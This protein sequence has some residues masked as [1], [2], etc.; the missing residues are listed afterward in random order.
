MNEFILGFNSEHFD[1][2]SG[3]TLLGNG[4]RGYN[5]VVMRSNS[6]DSMSPFGARGIN[7]YTYCTCDPLNQSDPSGHLSPGQLVSI[8][9]TLLAGIALGIAT[10]DAAIPVVLSLIASVAGE[11][12]IAAGA[13]LVTEA[14]DSQRVNWASVGIAA[15]LGAAS[16]FVGC[17][18]SSAYGVIKGSLTRATT[19]MGGI[20][21]KSGIRPWGGDLGNINVLGHSDPEETFI[22]TFDDS[23]RNLRRLNILGHG[24]VFNGVGLA[25]FRDVD[26][27]V[28]SYNGSE[29]AEM[30]R[31]TGTDF[32]QYQYARTILCHSAEGDGVQNHSFAGR[33]AE[34][35]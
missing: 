29:F 24:S 10:D 23:Y 18:I 30:L 11:A 4:Y 21:S 35:S 15:G 16:T 19:S 31:D 22:L 17:G 33:F 20:S 32:S 26:N 12:A 27:T 9:V 28:I 7:P 1:P 2:V 14:V 5:P 25:R 13:V 8:G 6:P 34:L 3:T